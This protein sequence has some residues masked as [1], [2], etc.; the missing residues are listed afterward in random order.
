MRHSC[1]ARCL[2]E[3]LESVFHA[4]ENPSHSCP[5][6]IFPQDQLP[7]FYD[8]DAFACIERELGR[9]LDSIFEVISPSPIAAASLGQVRG[10]HCT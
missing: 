1:V 9:P 5:P 3:K 2:Q 8:S 4:L 7:T 6:L 10:S